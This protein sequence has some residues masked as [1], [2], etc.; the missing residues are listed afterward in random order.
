MKLRFPIS[1]FRSP[2][3]KKLSAEAAFSRDIGPCVNRQSPIANHQSP[4]V[5]RHSSLATRHS[6]NGVA[7][8]IT[9]ILLA[10]TLV[11]AVAFLAVS[12]RGR[13]AVT[14]STDTATART[15]TDAALAAAQAQIAANVLATPSGA[16]NFSLL[17]STNFINANGFDP[18]VGANLANVNYDYRD[19]VNHTP[20]SSADLVQ[21]IAN[22]LLLPRAPV[23]IKTNAQGPND[24]R[25]YLDLN[26]NGLFETN[27][28]LPQIS[29]DPANPYFYFNPINA[30]DPR[31]G[32]T[33]PNILPGLTLSNS[34]T[35][36]PEWIGVLEHP[37]QPHGPNNHFIAR[38][39]YFAQAVGNGLDLNYVHNQTRNT[40]LGAADGFLRNQGVGSWELNLAAF[41]TDL[42]TNLWNP[43]TIFNP[44]INDPYIY[45]PPPS[46]GGNSG[47][48]FED[49]RALLSWRYG[50]NYNSLAV[51]S[52]PFYN[53]LVNAGIDG[54]TFGNLMTSTA[55]PVV[56]APGNTTPWA[57]SDSPNRFFSI[58]SD[59]FDLSKTTVG[60][61]PANILSG[62][63]L[64]GRLLSAGYAPSTYDRYTF[65]R[66]L[67]QLGTDSTPDAGK[68]NLNYSNA[69]VQY[70]ANSSP[71][72][73]AIIPGAETNFVPW[74]PRD[75]FTVAADMMLRHYSAQWFAANPTNYLLTF[76]N[77][78]PN[79]YSA[80]NGNFRA[81]GV[82]LTIPSLN[83][84]NTVPA[85]GITNI[86]V[87]FNGRLVYSPAVNRILQLAANLYDA[88]TNQTARYGK[89]Y[90]S[91]F[92]P[93]FSFSG[94]ASGTNRNVFISGYVDV[95]D[96]SSKNPLAGGRAPLDLPLDVTA[97]ALA[98]YAA[99]GTGSGNVYGVPWII[100]AKKGFPNF[101]QLMMRNT[102]QVTRKLQVSRPNGAVPGATGTNEMFT[103]SVTNRI[104]FSFWNSYES[105]YVA[106]PGGLTIFLSDTLS[107]RLTNDIP[108]NFPAIYDL[109]GNALPNPLLTNTQVAIPI[110]AGTIWPG[111]A[112]STYSGNSAR[113]QQTPDTNSF[114][115]VF[116]DYPFLPELDFHTSS[117][118]FAVSGAGPWDLANATVQT[119]PHFGLATTNWIQAYI[120]E[121]NNHIIDYVQ[122]SGPNSA[123]DLTEEIRDKVTDPG[124]QSNYYSGMLM[125]LTNT[126][127]GSTT[128]LGVM[129][130]IFVS[131]NNS[132]GSI[133]QFWKSP[134]NMPAG[135]QGVRAAESAYFSGFFNGAYTYN[136]KTYVNTNTVMQVPY[137]PTRTA[138]EYTSWQANDPLVHY[139]ASDL[140][141][142]TRQT[143]IHKGDV[144]ANVDY[145]SPNLNA[146]TDRYQPWGR[147]RQMSQLGNNVDPNAFN[148]RCR[149]PLV[150]GSDYWDFPTYKYP[151]VGWIGRVHRGTPWQTVYLKASDV[152]AESV[153]F[154]GQQVNVGLNTWAQWTG[155]T[156][157][158]YGLLFDSAVSAPVIDSDLFDMFTARVN[159]NAARG[160]LSVNQTHLAA[161]SAVFSGAVALANITDV[162]ASYTTPVITN[163]FVPPAGPAGALSPLGWI[164]NGPSGIN[165]TRANFVNAD[166]VVGTFE[167][168]G[169][170]LRAPALTE[171]SPFI[172]VQ[173]S[174]SAGD[175]LKY[176]ISD[177][178]YEWLPQQ[179]MGLL[180]VSSTPRYVIYCY[181]Q[182]L[183]PAPN[184]L[185]TSGGQ[186]FGLCTNYQVVAESAARAV[187]R[188]NRNT[189]TNTVSG[190]VS[191]NYTTTVEGYNT[192]PPD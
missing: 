73:M 100:G 140:N 19:D 52:A 10:V 154:G 16:Y 44:T 127:P 125:W 64:V 24:F 115:S 14:T 21:N 175:R 85:F 108:T 58:A 166:G 105:N 120:L 80:L 17:V 183:R 188:V 160:T 53:A 45:N 37:D 137:T 133:P 169:D 11:M 191:T 139:L 7:L 176:D 30:N 126:H 106:G 122:L 6:E 117:N 177:E 182:A 74:M 22:L 51:P 99:A 178:V 70:G 134:P 83:L 180:R 47:A 157:L 2:I 135:F 3:C 187:V 82:G 72:F 8:I 129:D 4:I 103:M 79:D 116:I 96:Y 48:A 43:P 138:W 155:D 35:G 170:I 49:A 104:G 95:S 161:W 173:D 112:W 1:E 39:A 28:L 189:F 9:L 63:F 71:I 75:F 113:E 174:V 144:L 38:Y 102:A 36:D 62:N 107:M 33:M 156:L 56:V 13:S 119:M 15:A 184:S 97:P 18:A 142:F 60:V 93:M 143:G 61:P 114:V 69:V 40:S 91:V 59:L 149:D 68:L 165:F 136:G 5:T 42:N 118:S 29:P 54:Y 190:L 162:P 123:R 88:S 159:D 152:R 109:F 66:L 171:Q 186:N 172:N 94:A 148:L 12:R 67:E 185:V 65:Y 77:L 158:T 34:V 153:P 90:P 81:D 55:L 192:L 130:Q 179:V 89:D 168:V 76:Y 150:W 147:N 26:R 132:A 146:L 151:T 101:N 32:Q 98:P 163:V 121:G 78:G 111:S 110:L 167:H 84:A 141:T 41:F 164:V 145:P 31:N 92:R 181:G 124:F 87:Y 50:G 128:P 131:A 86:P 46:V 57:G 27:G 23:L 25:F 20:L